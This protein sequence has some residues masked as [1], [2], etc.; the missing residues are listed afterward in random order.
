MKLKGRRFETMPG[1]QRESQAALHSIEE[2]DFRCAF[3]VW[4]KRED[5]CVRSQGDYSE[6]DISQT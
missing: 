5:R 1:I 3:E 2:N 4:K 6:G